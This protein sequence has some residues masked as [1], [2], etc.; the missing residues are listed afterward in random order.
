M[1]LCYKIGEKAP[2]KSDYTKRLWNAC[3]EPSKNKCKKSVCNDAVKV[4]LF[5][6]GIQIHLA[7][8]ASVA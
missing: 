4:A 1:I 2:S 5:T 8:F 3:Y 7:V 6:K